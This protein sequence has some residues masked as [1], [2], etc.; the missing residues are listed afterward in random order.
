MTWPCSLT[1]L[2]D[3]LP[4]GQDTLYPFGQSSTIAAGA[5]GGEAAGAA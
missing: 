4:G 3:H 5:A 1:M 2:R